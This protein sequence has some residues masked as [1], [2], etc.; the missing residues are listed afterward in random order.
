MFEDEFILHSDRTQAKNT[1]ATITLNNTNKIAIAVG[2]AL[3]AEKPAS[4]KRHDPPL[5]LDFLD[6]VTA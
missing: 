3:Y 6:S 5:A 1:T 4:T 2:T